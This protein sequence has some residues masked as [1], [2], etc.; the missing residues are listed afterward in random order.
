MQVDRA[1]LRLSFFRLTVNSLILERRTQY[2]SN[3][4]IYHRHHISELIYRGLQ[5]A[6]TLLSFAVPLLIN[7]CRFLSWTPDRSDDYTSSVWLAA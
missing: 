2:F 1:Q 4:T 5:R 7:P 3:S 6:M